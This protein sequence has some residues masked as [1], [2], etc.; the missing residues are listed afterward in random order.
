MTL[1]PDV[2]VGSVIAKLS[3]KTATYWQNV[4]F[5]SIA[6]DCKDPSSSRFPL[7]I[8]SS[9]GHVRTT[10]AFKAIPRSKIKATFSVPTTKNATSQRNLV[11][12]VICPFNSTQNFYRHLIESEDR[13]LEKY[14]CIDI[15]YI[16]AKNARV[17]LSPAAY[18]FNFHR[19]K[20][21]YD[22]FILEV[23]MNKMA[24]YFNHS[25]TVMVNFRAFASNNSTQSVAVKILQRSLV[26]SAKAKSEGNIVR[27]PI[28]EAFKFSIEGMIVTFPL[29]G[30][31]EYLD[32]NRSN[33]RVRY[34]PFVEGAVKLVMLSKRSSDECNKYKCPEPSKKETNGNDSSKACLTIEQLY[35]AC[36]C[37]FHIYNAQ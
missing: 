14:R 35:N 32:R 3:A 30:Q 24:R 27:V 36:N 20:S 1:I 11:I 13:V 7:C 16:L 21:Y 25:N 22:S 10:T 26:F 37:K 9:S 8:N 23:D 15:R 18:T 34:I 33:L 19:R 17:G 29:I 5:D 28:D 2:P 12:D 6:R 31:T 4:V